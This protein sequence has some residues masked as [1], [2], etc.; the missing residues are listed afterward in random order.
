M[1]GSS[2]H[3]TSVKVGWVVVMGW[4]SYRDFFLNF[5]KGVILGEKCAKYI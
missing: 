4:L 5:I 1:K 3:E 2:A